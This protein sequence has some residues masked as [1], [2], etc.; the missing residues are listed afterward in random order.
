MYLYKSR[1]VNIKMRTNSV[2][3]VCL[4]TTDDKIYFD[5]QFKIQVTF[6]STHLKKIC[7][8]YINFHINDKDVNA[9]FN[10]PECFQHLYGLLKW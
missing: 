7:P 2:C 9:H 4:I 3:I 6:N 10:N 5:I 8:N 1:N